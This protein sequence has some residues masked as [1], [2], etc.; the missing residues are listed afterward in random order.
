MQRHRVGLRQVGLELI[1]LPGIAGH[2][3]FQ[4]CLLVCGQR[5]CRGIDP[6]RVGREGFSFQQ[7]RARVDTQRAADHAQ[8]AAA[9]VVEQRVDQHGAYERCRQRVV[10]AREHQRRGAAGLEGAIIVLHRVSGDIV[11]QAHALAD[12]YAKCGGIDAAGVGA[13]RLAIQQQRARV[14]PQRAIDGAQR[15][16]GVGIAQAVHQPGKGD[17]PRRQIVAAGM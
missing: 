2:L 4:A 5:K 14:G 13:E 16:A 1:V 12:R 17:Q 11:A 3:V 6:A 7:Q 8:R 15:C 9:G 10:P